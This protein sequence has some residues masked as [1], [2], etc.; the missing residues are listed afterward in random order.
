MA[1]VHQGVTVWRTLLPLLL[2]LLLLPHHHR[3]VAAAALAT[4]NVALAGQHIPV[5]TTSTSMSGPCCRVWGVPQG[6]NSKHA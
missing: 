4:S 2:L 5:V 3:V 1:P 6:Y